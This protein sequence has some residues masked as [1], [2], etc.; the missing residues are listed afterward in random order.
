MM[1]V[2]Y[3]ILKMMESSK[4]ANKQRVAKQNRKQSV[5]RSLMHSTGNSFIVHIHFSSLSLHSTK[6]IYWFWLNG[7][8]NKPIRHTSM[9]QKENYRKTVDSSHSV[10]IKYII[11][12]NRLS[13]SYPKKN[14]KTK[15]V[16]KMYSRHEFI[17]PDFSIL[18]FELICFFPSKIIIGN[19]G[20]LIC[21]LHTNFTNSLETRTKQG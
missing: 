13:F 11:G 7:K 16:A 5:N 14:K 12:C 4:E 19:C 9:R 20:L 18:P 2:K 1:Q 8:R 10:W 15:S 21:I 17:L 6:N 3:Y